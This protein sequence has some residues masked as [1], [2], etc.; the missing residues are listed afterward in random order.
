[1]PS[2]R[3]YMEAGRRAQEK[4]AQRQREAAQAEQFMDNLTFGV[5]RSDGR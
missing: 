5:M 3:A 1:M 2:S 4:E